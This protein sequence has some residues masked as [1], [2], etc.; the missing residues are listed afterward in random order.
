MSI[1]HHRTL[2]IVAATMMVLLL[3]GC[4]EEGHTDEARTSGQGVDSEACEAGSHEQCDRID[5][6]CDGEIDEGILDCDPPSADPASTA[7]SAGCTDADG[8]GAYVCGDSRPPQDCD[9]NDPLAHPD[10]HEQCDGVDNDCDGVVDE[11]ILNCDPDS[12][13]PEPGSPGDG[14]VDADGDGA[15]VCTSAHSVN[16]CDDDNADVRPGWHESCD[17][18]DNDCDGEIDE[19][20]LNCN[21]DPQ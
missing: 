18:L 7:P 3:P 12:A 9:D 21:A 20:I 8:D 19:D 6:D 13:D 2:S 15:P 1:N 17:G 10:Y 4:G 14:C 11:D 16:D 5:N